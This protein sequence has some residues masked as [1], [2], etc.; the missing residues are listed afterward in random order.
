MWKKVFPS[1]MFDPSRILSAI[2]NVVKTRFIALLNLHRTLL[3]RKFSQILMTFSL[4]ELDESCGWGEH[5]QKS[6]KIEFILDEN[7]NSIRGCT[8]FLGN[9]LIKRL[10]RKLMLENYRREI[11]DI[12]EINS[13]QIE[14]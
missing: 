12:S 1:T 7:L 8:D 2:L 4:G 5:A 13:Q 10:F 14:L 9:Q 6:P 11:C 3:R